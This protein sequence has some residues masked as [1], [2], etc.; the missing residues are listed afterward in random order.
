[1]GKP[2][3]PLISAPSINQLRFVMMHAFLL[4]GPATAMHAA[5]MASGTSGSFR[6]TRSTLLKVE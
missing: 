3:C 6:K 5:L 2:K 4:T 1:V